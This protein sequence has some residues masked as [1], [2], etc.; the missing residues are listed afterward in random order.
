M[1]DAYALAVFIG[2]AVAFDALEKYIEHMP[3]YR[4]IARTLKHASLAAPWAWH[5]L[6][7]FVEHLMIHGHA[8]VY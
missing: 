4:Q 1:E 6:R 3:E 2:I 7:Q 8:Y 5:G